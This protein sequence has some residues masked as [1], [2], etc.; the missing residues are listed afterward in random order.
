MR[1]WNLIRRNM[2][3]GH[4]L[5]LILVVSLVS[6]VSTIYFQKTNSR[7]L[8]KSLDDTVNNAV[9][10]A[11]IGY[12]TPLWNLDMGS[13]IHLNEALLNNQMLIAV[14]VFS[15]GAFIAGNEKVILPGGKTVLLTL[16]RPYGATDDPFIKRIENDIVYSSQRIGLVQIFYTEK[17]VAQAVRM[18]TIRIGFSFTIIALAIIVFVFINLNRAAIRPILNL[19]RISQ[20][21][22]TGSDYSIRVEKPSMDEVGVLYDGFNNMLEQIQRREEERRLAQKELQRAMNLLDNVLDS[23]P[24]VLIATDMDHHITHWNQ[25]ASTLTG[26]SE[27]AAIG[28][29]LYAAYPALEQFR[30]DFAAV[31]ESLKPRELYRASFNGDGRC[32]NISIYPIVTDT[33]AGMV[34]RVDDVTEL[35]LKEQELRHVQKMEIIGMLAG[36]IAHDFN[37][38][39][40][41]II[42]AVSIFQHKLSSGREMARADLEKFIDVMQ[43]AGLRASDIVQ[44]LLNLSRKHEAILKPVDIR[45]TVQ[46]VLKICGTTFD[47]NIQIV[48]RLPDEPPMINADPAQ[49]EQVLLNFCVNANHAMTIMRED[50]RDAGGTL[51]IDVEH[52]VVDSHFK[53]AHPLAQHDRYWRIAVGDTGVGMD[54]ETLSHVF[55]PF[56]TTKPKGT[57]TGL[58]LTMAYNI[59]Q[60]HGGFINTYS[61]K[62]LGTTF[63]IY[64][65]VP[66]DSVTEEPTGERDD[67]YSGSGLIMVVDDE[68]VVRHTAKVILEECGYQVI[69]ASDGAQAVDIFRQRH[70]EISAVLLDMVMP[71]M[72]G[73]EAYLAMKSIDEDVKV[74]L[75]SGFKQDERVETVL[76]LG[77]HHF[78]Q[79]PYTLRE[80]SRAMHQVL[81]E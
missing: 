55:D 61:E 48:S 27:S 67:V 76:K 50:G 15:D 58:G 23:M 4:L 1:P 69:L 7:A 18:G 68:D 32:Y 5:T 9:S 38:L 56:F 2:V 78:I 79:K 10:F 59:V 20:E 6:A 42:G 43:N 72:I 53:E 46:S 57:G 40:V 33:P 35:E 26:I 62:G 52:V 21:V 65:P 13:I 64:L 14:N 54:R 63:C 60:Q 36:G 28:Q 75:S 41:G 37:N 3:V 70:H 30:E 25:S 47:K 81:A 12:S 31:L 77:I 39:L 73:K 11:L 80:L 29:D 49:L 51:T 8:R 44:Q 74:L 71:G 19:A 34:V 45:H 17:Y 16:A 22:A 24:S 66:K